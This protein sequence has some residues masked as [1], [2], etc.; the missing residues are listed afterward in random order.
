MKPVFLLFLM[1]FA[2]SELFSQDYKICFNGS[3]SSLTVESVTV[4]NLTQGTSL[5]INGSDTLNL[6]AVITGVNV[7]ANPKNKSINIYP[8]PVIS[9]CTLEFSTI[10]DGNVFIEIFDLA[11][12]LVIKTNENLAR[13]NHFFKISGLHAGVYIVK[14]TSGQYSYVTKLVSEQQ[15]GN[16]GRIVYQSSKLYSGLKSASIKVAKMQYN[17]GDKLKFKGVSGIYSTI[18]TDMPTSSKTIDFKFI[19]CTDGDN[20]HYSV[21]AMGNNFYWMAENLRTTKYNNGSDIPNVTDNAIWQTLKTPA[22]CWYNNDPVSYK[23]PYGAFYNYYIAQNAINVCPSGWHISTSDEWSSLVNNFGGETMAGGKLKET[24]T[25]HWF[26]P[27][28]DAIDEKGFSAVAG[29]MVSNSFSSIKMNGLWMSPDP[30]NIYN[31]YDV[32]Y[33]MGYNKATVMKNNYSKGTG[34][35][36][37]CVFDNKIPNVDFI[38]SKNTFNP[39]ESIHFIDRSNPVPSGWLWNFGDGQTSTQRDPYHTY[40]T[41]GQF[42]V[43]LTVT[44][45]VGSNSGSRTVVCESSGGCP[46]C[47]TG[48]VTDVQG[49]IYKTI[50]IGD[51]WWMAEDLKVTKYR[52]G[53]TIS[54]VADGTAWRNLTTGAYCNVNIEPFKDP[55]IYVD[56]GK[57]YN[58]Y[59]VTDK[60]NICPEGWHIPL[61]AEMLKLINY[62]GGETVAGGKIKKAGIAHW[63]SPNTGATN[64]S[65]FSALPA[66]IRDWGEYTTAIGSQASYWSSSVGTSEHT[67]YQISVSYNS[68]SLVKIQTYK[69]GGACVRCIKD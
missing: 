8:N 13:G 43:T 27:N 39:D 32:A 42:T 15:H 53:T 7:Q 41:V 38:A 69:N 55:V 21:V 29:G 40:T 17:T 62:L 23:E 61:E 28:A 25:T 30:S 51:Q 65:G 46:T 6:K 10:N 50:K 33:I 54:N 2:F 11:G 12:K 35:S 34:L 18:I 3:G 64:E 22:Y 5:T 26:S 19:D 47:E 48:T 49:N 4:E 1:L 36:I 31:P 37:R 58:F 59:A 52:D 60:R 57:L 63:N 67:A 56:Y 68:A 14:M 66:G 44:N 9:D 24:G 45:S 20:N 16:S